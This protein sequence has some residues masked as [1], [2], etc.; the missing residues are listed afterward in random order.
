MYGKQF[1]K[2]SQ[3]LLWTDTDQN[4]SFS[5]SSYL[6]PIQRILQNEVMIARTEANSILD[7][8]QFNE[9]YLL[10]VGPDLITFFG[11]TITV[12]Y[13]VVIGWLIKWVQL[14]PA[15]NHSPALNRPC[16]RA[17]RQLTYSLSFSTHSVFPLHFAMSRLVLFRP[18]SK[19]P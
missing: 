2:T 11:R 3:E 7:L 5:D 12:P 4:D 10:L 14:T 17:S 18:V 6:F 13:D 9:G 19:T 16:L 15:L 8:G 1:V